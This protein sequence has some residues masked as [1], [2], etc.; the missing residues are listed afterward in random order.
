MEFRQVRR[1]VEKYHLNTQDLNLEEFTILKNDEKLLAF[2]CVRTTENYAEL[3]CI[4]TVDE[5]KSKDWASM[6]IKKLVD[7]GPQTIWL[8]TDSPR[9]YEQFN[10]V[11]TKQI[12][13]ELARRLEGG[14]PNGKNRLKGMVLTKKK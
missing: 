1:L 12:P 2:G 8:A 5:R 13:K 7:C 10:F 11:T 9:F 14:E 6:I 4:G 3:D